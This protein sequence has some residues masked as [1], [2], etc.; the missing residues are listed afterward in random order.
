LNEAQEQRN[1]GETPLEDQVIEFFDERIA[2]E[3]ASLNA[4]ETISYDRWTEI[5]GDVIRKYNAEVANPGGARDENGNFNDF[6]E[7]RRP[8]VEPTQEG[9]AQ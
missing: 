6:I 9:H 3:T 8:F 5:L 1:A 2:E 7:V 4:G